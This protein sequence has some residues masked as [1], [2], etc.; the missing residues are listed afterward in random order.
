MRWK[1]IPW[2]TIGTIGL[3][4]GAALASNSGI[5]PFDTAANMV[6][7]V[8]IGAGLVGMS[9]GTLGALNHVRGGDWSGALN[10]SGL[11]I[12]SGAMTMLSPTIGTEIGGVA[13]AL[14]HHP[15]VHAALH[16]ALRAFA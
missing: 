4:A 13:A 16:L 6:E 15:I 9:A 7:K 8:I 2:M 10:H 3:M 12:G 5:A 14:I 1:T 11:A